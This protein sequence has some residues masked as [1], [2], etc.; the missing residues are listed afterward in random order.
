M[1]QQISLIGSSIYVR[2]PNF[3]IIY[4]WLNKIKEL[5]PAFLV[6]L[7]IGTTMWHKKEVRLNPNCEFVELR[8]GQII[9]LQFTYA[10]LLHLQLF[11][12][13]HFAKNT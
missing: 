3:V 7:N 1:Q 13:L 12:K 11:T 5:L 6:K 8:D 10:Y 2:D 4:E 9:F